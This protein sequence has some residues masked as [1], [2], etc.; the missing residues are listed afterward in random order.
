MSIMA[1]SKAKQRSNHVIG[2]VCSEGNESGDGE[3]K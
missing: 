3:M 1:S 2:K